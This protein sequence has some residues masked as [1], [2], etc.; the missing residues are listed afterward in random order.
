MSDTQAVDPRI[1]SAISHWLP[2]F[3][4]H[5][6]AMG[7]F[8]EVTRGL[9]SWDQWCAAWSRRGRLHADL[10]R[11]AEVE[12]R[13]VSAGEH[14]LTAALCHH[15]GKFLFLQDVDQ[16][17]EAHEQAVDLYTR[18]LPYLRPPGERC[19]VPYDDSVL[20]GILRLPVGVERP[21]VVVLVAGLDSTKEEQGP[22]ERALLD[23]GLATFSFDGPGQG[24][25]EYEHPM[26]ADFEVPVAAVIDHLGTRTDVD[27]GRIALW[28]RS[29]GGRH[30]IRAAAFEPRVR[31]CVSLSGPYD[32]TEMW[33]ER[34]E[35]NRQAYIV[36]SHSADA[37][38]ALEKLA[39]FS[40]DDVACR[41]TCPTYVLAGERDRLT[42]AAHA[43]RIAAE[44]SGPVRLNI[45][46]GGSHTSSNKPYA[47]RPEAADWVLAQLEA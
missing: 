26:R 47:Y 33:D 35:L 43:E 29:F 25:A 38:E 39:A 18:A 21:P 15:Y 41:V 36:R 10:A 32:P 20:Y 9:T 2:R 37:Q 22:H 6:I 44:V 3:M 34:P 11:R 4:T 19:A 5:G 27:G 12:G 28:G 40:L 42:P 13:L 16:M 31:A 14:Y 8:E 23:R 17:L 30:V 1:R 24:E 46:E 7:D 45:V